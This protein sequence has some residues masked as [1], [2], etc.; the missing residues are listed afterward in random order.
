MLE[1]KT[2]VHQIALELPA[3]LS[4]DSEDPD[5]EPRVYDSITRLINSKGLLL[6]LSPGNDH[7]LKEGDYATCTL[8][9]KRKLFYSGCLVIKIKANQVALKFVDT[10]FERLMVLKFILESVKRR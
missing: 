10:D 9:Y 3:K 5:A 1:E 6:T 4:V 8:S 2:A 7:T